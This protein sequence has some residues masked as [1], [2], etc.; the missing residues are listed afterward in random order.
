[1]NYNEIFL[2]SAIARSTQAAAIPDFG[3]MAAASGKRLTK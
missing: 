3:K 1:L 2:N